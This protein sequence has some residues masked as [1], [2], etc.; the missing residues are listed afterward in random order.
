[1]NPLICRLATSPTH[2]PIEI[3]PGLLNDTAKLLK[4]LAPLGSKFAII[5]D[6]LVSLLHGQKL[7]IDLMQA[8]LNVHLLT[9]PEGEQYK[10]RTTKESLENELFREGFGRDSCVIALGGGVVSDL[11]GY[12]AAT[13]CRGI[14][15]VIIPTSLMA[16]VDASIG[17]KT[18][19]NVPHGKNLLGCIYQPRYVLIDP[20]ALSTLPL[21]DLKHGL[22]EMIKYGLIADVHFFEY[23]EQN[24]SS[25]LSLD[26]VVIEKCLYN[27]CRIK[28][29]IIEEDT[30]EKGRR[31]ILNFGHTI[32]HALESLTH[33]QLPHGQAVAVGLLVESYLCVLIGKISKEV[34]DRIY[35]LITQYGIP[36][37][38]PEY[39][40]PEH[41]LEAMVLDKKSSKGVPR[42]VT[43]EAIGSPSYHDSQFCIEIDKKLIIDALGW[44]N[45]DLCGY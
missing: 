12:L 35:S 17:G 9:F 36:I 19:V 41:L 4:L 8:G 18:G 2:Y 10:I 27:C 14:P 13:Y 34:L 11:A 20:L 21:E 3:Q 16:M 24:T 43:I 33:Y 45:H 40:S 37:S 6:N 39:F 22:V 29:E 42:F 7:Y 26:S 44:M 1:M 25:I 23:L 31:R 38:V 30:L 15:L 32:G 5:T 28:K